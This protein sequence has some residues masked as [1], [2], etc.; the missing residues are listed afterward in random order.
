MGWK[1]QNATPTVFI[2][3]EPNFRINMAMIREY[4]VINVLAFYKK[5]LWHFEI[6]TRESIG[7]S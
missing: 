3:S 2:A 1:F 4:K 7:K 6:L 5:K